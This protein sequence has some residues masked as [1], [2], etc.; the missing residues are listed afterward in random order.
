MELN[1]DE[2]MKSHKGETQTEW[3]L[4]LA[5]VALERIANIGNIDHAILI[6]GNAIKNDRRRQRTCPEHG[7]MIPAQDGGYFCTACSAED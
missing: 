5:L 7:S 3:R 4:R 6:A 1:G 2:N